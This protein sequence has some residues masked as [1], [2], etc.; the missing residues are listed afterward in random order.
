MRES[1]PSTL[2]NGLL[3]LGGQVVRGAVAVL[4]I[5]FL[6]RFLGIAEYGVWSFGYAFLALLTMCEAGFSIAA[7]VF[8]SKD[9]AN[10]TR[11]A[12]QT[13]TFILISATL[14][15]TGLVV[16]LW[17]A[18]PL[19]AR[20]LTSFGAAQRAVAGRALQIAGFGAAIL[21]LQRTLAGVE[22]AFNRYALANALDLA[23]ALLTNLGFLAVASRNGGT[24]ALMEWQVFGS[25]LVLAAH[26]FVVTAICREHNLNLEW[27]GKKGR[28]IFRYSLGTWVA[29]LGSAAFGQCDRLI[30]GW[31]L[32]P[33]L[34]GIYSAITNITA[35]INTVSA[36]AV[37]PMVPMLS[38]DASL[39]T[40]TQ[41]RIRQAT[42]VN[43]LIAIGA[44]IFLFVVADWIVKVLGI[45]PG[46]GTYLLC[47]QAAV[48][49]Y[50]LYALS[51]P[52][53]FILFSIG[54]V[55]ANALII[56]CSGMMSLFLIYWGARFFGLLGAVIGNAGYLG[57]LLLVVVGLRKLGITLGRF[58][59]WTALPLLCLALAL[60]IGVTLQ[61]HFWWRAGFVI[62][63]AS[64]FMLWFI[65]NQGKAIWIELGVG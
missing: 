34:L 23:Q 58:L 61:D 41:E 45:G 35:K 53:Y 39:S 37:Q 60:V 8:L 46:A 33:S 52:G 40:P 21:I 50:T 59:E 3:N 17:F 65:H 13:L 38:R 47:L 20:S 64:L 32:G 57:T 5:P 9:L 24:V 7:V 4:T 55:R 6:I 15:S 43:A 28:R 29:T 62:I 63:Q 36:T 54:A 44:G 51:A 19:L 1:R 16:L 27:N 10:N 14:L 2:R 26:A 42:Q 49:I 12:G 31:T 18:G 25:I 11:E 30:V 48:V 22:Q 56:L